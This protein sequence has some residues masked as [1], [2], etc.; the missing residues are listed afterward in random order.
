MF[1]VAMNSISITPVI[2]ELGRLAS[3][4]WTS[5]HGLV[6][7]GLVVIWLELHGATEFDDLVIV[8]QIHELEKN[9]TKRGPAIAHFEMSPAEGN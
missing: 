8:P 1:V 2:E 9:N 5:R 7:N 6:R 4:L 3:N